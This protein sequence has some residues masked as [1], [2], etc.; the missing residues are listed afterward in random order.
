M[1]HVIQTLGKEM[2]EDEELR[3]RLGYMVDCWLT[4]ATWDLVSKKQERKIKRSRYKWQNGV[5]NVLESSSRKCLRGHSLFTRA[6][7]S[8]RRPWQMSGFGERQFLFHWVVC[9]WGVLM[10]WV[11][12]NVSL[13]SP[14][15]NTSCLSLRRQNWPGMWRVS[16]G[17]QGQGSAA[18]LLV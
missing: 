10:L 16:H 9:L 13:C 17:L 14:T 18:L 4:W 2:Q 3:A 8:G 6:Y 11:V 12:Y 1:D 15:P 5:R 7:L